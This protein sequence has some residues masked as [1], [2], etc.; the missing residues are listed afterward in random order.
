MKTIRES[1]V[2]QSLTR[3]GKK[4]FWMLC[5]YE[6]NGSYFYQKVYWQESLDGIKSK[7]QTSTP[8]EV[9][10]KNIGR[11]N[12][13]TDIE[14]LMSEFSS[15]L[16]KQR[17]KGYS[18]D[19]S[20]DHNPVKPMLANKYKDKKHKVVFPCFVQPK[21]DGFRMLKE[22]DGKVAWTRGGKEHVRE[23]VE[24][25]MWNTGTVMVDGELMLPH[26]PPLQETA[27]A[28]KKF[29]SD[30]SPTLKYFVYDVV[31]S[32]VPFAC[33]Y[34]MLKILVEYAP[35]NIV[36]VETLE[37][38]NEQELFE[39]HARFT[40]AGFEGTIIRSGEGGYEIGHRS[41]SLLKMKDFQDSE[42]LVTGIKEGKGSFVGHGILIC[43]TPEGKEFAA[44]PEG[45]M[46]YRASLWENRDEY[47]N[48]WATIRFQNL[49]EDGIPVF[50]IAVD[51]RE[52]GE[53]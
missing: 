16:Q 3:T 38:N 21:L 39:A 25:L 8:V 42:Y 15:I 6:N 7:V 46:D 45:T 5:A 47:V 18:E 26:M 29:R 34:E 30:V 28:A 13:T 14:Q 35:D 51:F 37:V 53:F 40:A 52:E 1:P 17:D 19:G 12:E 43:E 36:L 41:T 24:H 49:S 48:R 22:G 11:A 4:K 10:G 20:Q 31:E 23:C 44:T 27:R 2:L 32:T 9:V 50:P 33:R